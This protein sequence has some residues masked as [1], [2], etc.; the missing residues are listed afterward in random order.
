MGMEKISS[1]MNGRLQFRPFPLLAAVF[2]KIGWLNLARI[3]F[4]TFLEAP[5][6]SSKA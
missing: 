1:G 3:D 4:R 5:N 6:V 2:S